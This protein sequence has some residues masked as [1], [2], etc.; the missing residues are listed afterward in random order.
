MIFLINNRFILCNRRDRPW[1]SGVYR[2]QVGVF[3]CNTH[4]TL[5][6]FFFL[7]THTLHF[8]NILAI[9]VDLWY[10]RKFYI[11]KTTHFIPKLK[12]DLASDAVWEPGK[13]DKMPAQDLEES[14]KKR[15]SMKSALSRVLIPNFLKLAKTFII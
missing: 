2:I 7:Q 6:K 9:F 10:T 11:G 5:K 13:G 1:S 3:I 14:K 12:V 15:P 8:P 4:S